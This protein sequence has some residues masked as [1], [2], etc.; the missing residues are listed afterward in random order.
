MSCSQDK[1]L[2]L[3][4]GETSESCARSAADVAAALHSTIVIRRLSNRL[5]K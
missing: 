2:L 5:T 3:L 1:V 4:L